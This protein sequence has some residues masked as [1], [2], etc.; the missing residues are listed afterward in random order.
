LKCPSDTG[1][2]KNLLFK[3]ETKY[4]NT[5]WTLFW[6]AKHGCSRTHMLNNLIPAFDAQFLDCKTAHRLKTAV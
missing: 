4:F 6:R 5:D 3:V 2:Q 1:S